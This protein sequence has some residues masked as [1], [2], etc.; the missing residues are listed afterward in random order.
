MNYQI[1]KLDPTTIR[2]SILHKIA[3]YKSNRN[4]TTE[5]SQHVLEITRAQKISDAQYIL[6]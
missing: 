6:E 4:V 5:K 1:Y 3:N 2:T